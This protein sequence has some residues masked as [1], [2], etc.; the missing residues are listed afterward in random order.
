MRKFLFAVVFL[1]GLFFLKSV[2]SQAAYATTISGT[3]NNNNGS[4][5]VDVLVN[6]YNRDGLIDTRD[7]PV[8]GSSSTEAPFPVDVADDNGPFSVYWINECGNSG[9]VNNIPLSDGV[10]TFTPQ[11]VHC[12]NT[13]SSVSITATSCTTFTGR[14][15][16][17]V[18]GTNP[19]IDYF[20]VYKSLGSADS[21]TAPTTVDFTGTSPY[22]QSLSGLSSGTY[23]VKVV[24]FANSPNDDVTAS[25]A[26]GTFACGS[27]VVP[28]TGLSSSPYCD[29]SSPR[30]NLNWTLAT[31][32]TG[33]TITNQRVEAAIGS[34]PGPNGNWSS[35][36]LVGAS[37]T[38]TMVW[39][40]DTS[41]TY[42]WRINTQVTG[43]TWYPSASSSFITI[44]VCSA[45]AA[46]NLGQTTC[47]SGNA[48]SVT[49]TWIRGTPTASISLE[50]L[51]YTRDDPSFNPASIIQRTTV[52]GSSS[53][54]KTGFDFDN[55]TKYYWRI[56][57]KFIDSQWKTSAVK[58]FIAPSTCNPTPSPV[59]SACTSNTQNFSG[60]V[61]P[62][63][64]SLTSTSVRFRVN[65]NVSTGNRYFYHTLSVV[66]GISV[67]PAANV[68]EGGFIAVA[69]AGAVHYDVDV[70]LTDANLVTSQT[71]NF[72]MIICGTV[73]S[74]TLIISM[75][76]AV[77]NPS[78][79]T[80][81]SS[82]LN[83]GTASATPQIIFSWTDNSTNEDLFW[84]DV[85]T[86]QFTGPSSATPSS[87][88]GYKTRNSS[89]TEKDNTA[90]VSPPNQRSFTWD[91]T[92]PITNTTGA[93]T[94]GNANPQT[95]PTTDD[96][97]P[98]EDT[99]YY[100]RVRA[101]VDAG[102]VDS[103]HIYPSTGTVA[104]G[105][106]VTTLNCVTKFDLSATFVGQSLKYNGNS[107]TTV[108]ANG[109][110]TMEIEVKN[111]TSSS[112]NLSDSPATWLYFY[113]KGS[114]TGG[115]AM[116]SC[117]G[118]AKTISPADG[119][120]AA[121]TDEQKYPVFGL[122]K[123]GAQTQRITVTFNVGSTQDI[124]SAYAY[125][126]P[127]CTLTGGFETTT[128]NTWANNKTGSY[129][130]S[131]DVKT[132]F[133][134]KG[135]DVGASGTV[136]VGVNSS[137]F[138]GTKYYQ[139]DYVIAGTDINNANSNVQTNNGFLLDQYSGN[140]VLSGGVY[141]YFR[142][143]FRSKATVDLCTIIS[144]AAS[145][146]IIP[147]GTY[148]G[149]YYCICSP[150]LYTFGSGIEGN[151]VFFI[152]GDLTIFYDVVNQPLDTAV[153]I[154]SGNI[155]VKNNVNELD[156]VYIAGKSFIT[157]GSASSQL[158][159][160]GA[161]Y[162]DEGMALGRYFSTLALNGTTPTESF[163][164]DPKYFAALSTLLT[165]SISR[166]DRSG[167]RCWVL[168]SIR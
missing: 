111:G 108:P 104:T 149:L 161:V 145:P 117:P 83:P 119:D 101:H 129:G 168:R 51:E 16:W 42:Y 110:A 88:W 69:G 103:A 136:S 8:V 126:V 38:S 73:R 36:D 162:A 122:L 71:I 26:P 45:A 41:N 78:T 125:V 64:I 120:T 24:A 139:S 19:N 158:N 118:T 135:G 79:L 121:G 151:A 96:L 12:Q 20:K 95:G 81:A 27:P 159:V 124:Y 82:C 80:V 29:G 5:G 68:V 166:T 22:F 138:S 86:S 7:W 152:D 114:G 11:D 48:N 2:T 1:A 148:N 106:G 85:S 63:T 134:T 59:P 28:A 113:F 70:D 155:T 4:I 9:A 44:S 17:M 100:W 164:F 98:L 87:V 25:S 107:V 97:V 94:A 3:L 13:N 34:D 57:T 14:V 133:E 140:Q 153:F 142:S 54:A 61:T 93:L 56:N 75:P 128:P 23:N 127:D 60:P 147:A 76:S 115:E 21:D 146:P 67:S 143:R 53:F 58:F 154:V 30:A 167:I 157:Q 74:A 77:A 102:A 90:I 144:C 55:G 160:K 40:G 72:A 141:E 49:H 65:Y 99:T 165:H 43:G 66:P 156:G 130:Y 123:N 52:T 163:V 92:T 109:V 6:Y 18:N 31:V 33:V 137:A 131:V 47:V 105:A 150:L 91:N 10:Y 112:V 62:Q 37:A 84:V 32:P 50:E 46:T 39:T 116:P 89:A 35:G 132:F 15:D